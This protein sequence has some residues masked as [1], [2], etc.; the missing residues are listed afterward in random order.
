MIKRII[1]SGSYVKRGTGKIAR[2][3]SPGDRET[4]ERCDHYIQIFKE[5]LYGR[6]VVRAIIE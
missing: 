6:T 1:V 5:M 4:N 2:D 3:S